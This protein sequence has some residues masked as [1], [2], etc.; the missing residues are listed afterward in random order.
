MLLQTSLVQSERIWHGFVPFELYI[1]F[2]SSLL[3]FFFPLHTQI[4]YSVPVILYIFI[5]NCNS[6][7]RSISSFILNL[8]IFTHFNR[9]LLIVEFSC[10]FDSINL[11]CLFSPQRIWMSTSYSELHFFHLLLHK[12]V[13]AA[14]RL[15]FEREAQT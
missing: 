5:A 10:I 13:E 11:Y 6:S 15:N 9:H 1:N 2:Y 4:V 3:C 14:P 8:F 7:Q 12:L